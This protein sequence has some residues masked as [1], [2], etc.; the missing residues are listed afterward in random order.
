MIPPLTGKTIIS[1][2]PADQSA[3]LL[4]LLSQQGALAYNMPMIETRVITGALNEILKESQL[5]DYSLL[6]FTSRKGVDAFFELW[7]HASLPRHLKTAVVGPKTA[8]ALI[9]HGVEP[10]YL[11]PGHDAAALADYLITRVLQPTDGILLVLGSLAP[12]FLH[13]QLSPICLVRRVNVYQTLGIEKP[14]KKISE[15]ILSQKTDMCIFTSPSGFE[16]FVQ[17]YGLPQ[18]IP[19]AAIGT[20]TANAMRKAGINPCVVAAEPNSEALAQ[21]IVTFFTQP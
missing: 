15:L 14:D 7:P 21:S 4:E 9:N 1:T 16:N 12:D 13:T 19:L 8:E 10:T 11:N 3:A 2:Q 17:H 5:S 18:Q 6:I 20:T